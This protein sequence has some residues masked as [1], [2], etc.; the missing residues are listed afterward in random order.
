MYFYEV[1]RKSKRWPVKV[2]LR[3][4]QKALLNSYLIYKCATNKP[5]KR[6]RFYINV[7]EGL[8]YTLRNKRI[9]SAEIQGTPK[10]GTGCK[11]QILAGSR[12]DCVVCSDRFTKRKRTAYECIYCRRGCCP[13]F[14]WNIISTYRW[15]SDFSSRSKKRS[16]YLSKE[17]LASN[18]ASFCIHYLLLNLCNYNQPKSQ[19][20]SSAQK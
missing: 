13:T 14:L 6:I 8:M 18:N 19:F 15:T 10:G 12:N 9:M 11:L 20:W 7:S 4:M 3:L 5:M 17:L 1:E 16:I 2:I